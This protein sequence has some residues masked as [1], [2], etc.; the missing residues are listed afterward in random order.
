MCRRRFKFFFIEGQY[1]TQLKS[2][3]IKQIWCVDPILRC[4]Y[5]TNFFH[6][7]E[8]YLGQISS[9]KFWHNIWPIFFA[10]WRHNIWP[11]QNPK[12]W[13]KIG[14]ADATLWCIYTSNFISWF[15][16][17]K[18]PSCEAREARPRLFEEPARHRPRQ[19]QAGVCWSD[20]PI[21]NLIC[22]KYRPSVQQKFLRLY[23][24]Q[25][26]S[27]NHSNKLDVAC[28]R[29]RFKILKTFRLLTLGRIREFPWHSRLMSI[30]RQ[31]ALDRQ[32]N[33]S[34]FLHRFHW[35]NLYSPP[36]WLSLN[37]ASIWLVNASGHAPFPWTPS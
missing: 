7:W 22:A 32:R 6:G 33:P 31:S 17:W 5:A 8:F 36:D 26:K 2:Q 12:S 9:Q 37:L 3:I 27:P 34:I 1:L 15:E 10:S 11:K 30:Q 18:V 4:V 16:I 35:S 23:L 25:M 24:T 14:Y 28:R 29:C 13:K 20:H 19:G 21:W